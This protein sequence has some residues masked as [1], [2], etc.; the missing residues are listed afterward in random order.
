[1]KDFRG[2]YYDRLDATL[3]AKEE[4]GTFII[5]RERFCTMTLYRLYKVSNEPENKQVIKF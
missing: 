1:M 5:E 4:N 2:T 3:G